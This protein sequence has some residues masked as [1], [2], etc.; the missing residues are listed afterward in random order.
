MAQLAA[1]LKSIKQAVAMTAR[2]STQKVKPKKSTKRKNPMMSKLAQ[3]S[4]GLRP[5][6]P[7]AGPPATYNIVVPPRWECIGAV[8]S[9]GSA[10]DVSTYLVNPGNST[11]FPWLSAIAVNFE[12]YRF[13][14]LRFV[15]VSSSADAVGSTNTALGTVL[16][17]TNYD[18][19]DAE[20]GS[21]TAFEDYG[22]AAEGKP[23][24]DL[25]HVVNVRGRRGGEE[26]ARF[27]LPGSGNTSSSAGYPSSS[28]AHDY[29]LGLFQVGT[30]GQQ[31]SST[32][33]RLYVYYSVELIRA[34]TSTVTASAL[35]ANH[36]YTA[37]ANAS[38]SAPLGTSWTSGGGNTLPATRLSGTTFAIG[39]TG[40]FMVSLSWAAPNG[41]FAG[42]PTVA[43]T[44]NASSVNTFVNQTNPSSASYTSSAANLSFVVDI[45]SVAN[46]I[47]ITMPGSNAYHFDIFINRVPSGFTV[48][49][50]QRDLDDLTKLV[51]ELTRERQLRVEESDDEYLVEDDASAKSSKGRPRKFL[52]SQ[53]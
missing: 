18:V 16:L 51:R 15:F 34:K 9:T 19:L 5:V 28:S 24:E 20:F 25:T 35:V 31:A 14:M 8:A 3:G 49:D 11:T 10:L 37:T 2:A 22:G 42:S 41:S 36:S 23:S 12:K 1:E 21:Q 46:V 17:N 4:L 32:V 26:G 27:V 33:G 39:Q 45:A 47:T 44:A 13:R 52:G 29:D 40:R 6:G 30:V 48:R 43:L 53:S 38:S 50:L 7:T